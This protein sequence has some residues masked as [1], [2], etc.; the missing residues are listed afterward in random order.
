MIVRTSRPIPADAAYASRHHCAPASN[1]VS[2]VAAV[3]DSLN[4]PTASSLSRLVK[5]SIA[6]VGSAMNETAWTTASTAPSAASYAAQYQPWISSMFKITV[7]PH[8]APSTGPSTA[9]NDT[10]ANVG[11]AS[12]VNCDFIAATQPSCEGARIPVATRSHVRSAVSSA[13]CCSAEA[14]CSSE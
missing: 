7:T 9:H 3:T 12:R 2:S 11:N 13:A 8:T 10:A 1:D 14:F 5:N 4:N 6:W